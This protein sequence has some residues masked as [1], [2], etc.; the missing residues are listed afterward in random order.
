MTKISP[1][2]AAVIR[3]SVLL[4][5]CFIL[6]SPPRYALAE[7][8]IETELDVYYSNLGYYQSLSDS[9]IPEFVENDESSAYSR[10]LD[11]AFSLPRFMLLELGVYPLPYAA[12]YMK[13][14][15]ASAY[16]KVSI[17]NLNLIQAMTAGYEEPYALSLFLGSIV[18]FVQ[19]GEE[20]KIKNR[21]YT[22]FLFS[23]G[24]Q[25]IVINNLVADNWYELEWKVKGDQDFE[26]KT[27]S[28]SMRFGGKFHENSNITDVFYVGVRRNHLDA[29]SDDISWFQNADIDFK[30]ELN[31]RTFDITRL[32]LFINKK[33]PAPLFK[34]SAFE[35]GV[36]VIHERN[37]YI[38][39]LAQKS[40]DLQLILR[41]SFKF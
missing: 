29:A 10:L 8:T 1:L 25:H 15:H 33:W 16:D 37:K 23:M 31:S 36:G 11:S 2:L 22:G 6:L 34:K 40:R 7:Y 18:R 35:F 39:E 38:G 30:M 19:P 20:K 28:W 21:G 9:P 13:E 12:A 27:L 14:Q 26:N 17:G 4:I 24:D 41:P 32:N 5:F 3:L